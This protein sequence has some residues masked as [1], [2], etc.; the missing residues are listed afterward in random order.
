MTGIGI[1]CDVHASCDTVDRLVQATKDYQ[2]NVDAHPR[3]S[4]TLGPN[5]NTW[6]KSLFATEGINLPI[7]TSGVPAS[8]QYSES[9]VH[10][11]VGRVTLRRI[12]SICILVAV[13][14]SCGRPPLSNDVLDELAEL[15][16]NTGITIGFQGDQDV[17]FIRFDRDREMRVTGLLPD[18]VR[19]IER[20][21]PA[22]PVSVP[23]GSDGQR[24]P[25]GRWITYR[26][27]TNVFVLANSGGHSSQA[28]FEGSD[29]LT[30]L[31]WSPD[32][33][34]LMYVLRSKRFDENALRTLADGLDLM[35]LRVRDRKGGRL[36][37]FFEG[38]PFAS[39]RWIKLP[40]AVMAR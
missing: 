2:A 11:K 23:N 16:R 18:E 12:P 1:H 4:P 19:M 33:R 25:D 35:I 32:S 13:S 7:T 10:S 6:L 9:S 28:L 15:Q 36:L 38:F 24:S 31:Y 5:S 34:Y 20:S 29:V 39:L 27:N 37:Q 3:Y 30:P 17:D 14:I 22:Q 26:T 40:S 8:V 21:S